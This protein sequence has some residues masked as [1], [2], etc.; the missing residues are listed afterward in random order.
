MAASATFALKSGEWF[1]RVRFVIFA[2]DSHAQPCALSGRDSTHRTDRNCGATSSD[3]GAPG[4]SQSTTR[5]WSSCAVERRERLTSE[6]GPDGSGSKPGMEPWTHMPEKSGMDAALSLPLLAGAT[7][8]ATACP[9]AGV[10]A[11]AASV[12]TRRTSRRCKVMLSSLF[13]GFRR[14]SRIKLHPVHLR[15]EGERDVC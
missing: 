6:V 7:V 4:P 8:G 3:G 2:P 1:R 5:S 10:A 15:L 9:K 12:T 14:S 13:M 11:A